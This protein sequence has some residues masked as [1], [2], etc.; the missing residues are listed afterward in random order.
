MNINI[1]Q[2]YEWNGKKI[3]ELLK[4]GKS[5]ILDL[6]Y[7]LEIINIEKNILRNEM[8]RIMK[9]INRLYENNNDNSHI[10]L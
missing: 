1:E 10:R 4:M 5:K 7:N 3:C 8:D 6:E 9:D 2:I